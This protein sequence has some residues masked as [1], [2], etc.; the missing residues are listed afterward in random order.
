MR[1]LAEVAARDEL[2]VGEALAG[3]LDL[4]RA[5][6]PDVMRALF[7]PREPTDWH[8]AT[9]LRRE[10]PLRPEGSVRRGRRG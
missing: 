2:S 6:H 8:V 7:L 10:S 4:V 1:D 5:R 3:V 9:M